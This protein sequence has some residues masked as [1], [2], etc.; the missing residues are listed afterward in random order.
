M[1]SNGLIDLIEKY[2]YGQF[3]ILDNGMKISYNLKTKQVKFDPFYRYDL[4]PTI[5]SCGELMNTAYLDISEKYSELHVTRVLGNDPNFFKNPESKHCFLFVSEEDLIDNKYYTYESRDIEKALLKNPLIVDPSFNRVVPFLESGYG[6]QGLINQR[7]RGSY[8]NTNIVHNKKGIPLGID[9][10]GRI[11]YLMVN[12][13]SPQL[14][15]IG[16]QESD[17]KTL[18]YKLD[19]QELDYKFTNDSDILRFID[20]LRKREKFEVFHEFEVENNIIIE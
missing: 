3:N 9:S 16:I 18:L 19:S 1:D 12:F 4:R 6:V 7:C 8:S 20:L 13:D 10:H 14:I 15:D 2:E 17:N 11:V 5:G